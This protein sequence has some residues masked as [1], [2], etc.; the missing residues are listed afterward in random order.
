MDRLHYEKDPCVKYDL[1]KKLWIYLHKNRGLDY[2]PWNEHLKKTEIKTEI[3]LH[4]DK[5]LDLS[6]ISQS[7]PPKHS[8]NVIDIM[9]LSAIV[10]QSLIQNPTPTKKGK[11]DKKDKKERGDKMLKHKRKNSQQI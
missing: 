10:S 8:D 1:Q 4:D 7:L 2:A 6:N 9:N 11:K 3:E 5:L